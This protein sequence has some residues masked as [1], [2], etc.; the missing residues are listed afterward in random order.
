[1]LVGEPPPA[2]RSVKLAKLLLAILDFTEPDSPRGFDSG[3]KTKLDRA[4]LVSLDSIDCYIK[5]P[6][7]R[8]AESDTIGKLAHTIEL[9]ADIRGSD[10]GRCRVLLARNRGLKSLSVSLAISN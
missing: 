10:N 7:A 8:A 5:W 1:M 4:W 9:L 6:S 2:L 3:I